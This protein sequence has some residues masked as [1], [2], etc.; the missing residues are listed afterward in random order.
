MSNPDSDESISIMAGIFNEEAFKQ[1]YQ[2]LS[3]EP[4]TVENYSSGHVTA[5]VTTNGGLLV[6][7]IPYDP[8]WKLKVDGVAVTPS[9]FGD[10]L[11]A[12]DLG[13]GT[14]TLEFNYTPQGFR[15]GFLISAISLL[16][17]IG[18]VLGQYFYRKSVTADQPDIEFLDDDD[19]EVPEETAD[20]ASSEPLLSDL[21]P[22]PAQPSPSDDTKEK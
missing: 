2:E 5:S 14:H 9:S 11:L 3:Q 16:L 6:T 8:G 19:D 4:M 12:F 13:A 7:S 18:I 22:T 20:A 10:A 21:E 15:L 17:L 1:A